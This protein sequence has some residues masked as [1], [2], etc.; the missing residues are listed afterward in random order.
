MLRRAI[1]S[2]I[3]QTMACEVIVVDEAST[4]DTPNVVGQYPGVVYIRN[5]QPLGHSGAANKGI[6]AAQ[7]DWIKPVDDDDWLAPNC[8]SAL[9]GAVSI[10]LARGKNPVIASG[11][12]VNVD[13]HEAILGETRQLDPGLVCLPSR[14]LLEMMMIEQAPIGTPV[15]VGH[16]RAAAIACGGWNVDRKVSLQYGDET[17]FWIKLAARGDAVFLPDIVS[18]RTI[19]AQGTAASSAHCERFSGNMHLKKLIAQSLNISIEP[20]VQGF[21]ALHWGLVALKD[22]KVSESIPLL[23]K[24]LTQP[25][26]FKLFLD[27]RKMRQVKPLLE[28]L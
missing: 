23:G 7:G 8:I 13:E 15:Q 9:D 2:C 18:Y 25:S 4:D 20:A 22:K 5:A 10:A 3:K 6:S 14:Q 21:V 1:E 26:A 19:W 24:A 16:S 17:E 28:H 11:R 12:S 27:Q